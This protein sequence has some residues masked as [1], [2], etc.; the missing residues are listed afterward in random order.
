MMYQKYE[1]LRQE[2]PTHRFIMLTLTLENPPITELRQSKDQDYFGSFNG[3]I[4]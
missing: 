4:G 2:Y 3:S 1:Q